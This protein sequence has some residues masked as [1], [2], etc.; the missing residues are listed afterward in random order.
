ML[1]VACEIWVLI[2]LYVELADH[3]IP[4]V[5]CGQ[6]AVRDAR[7]WSPMRRSCAWA[8]RRSFTPTMVPGDGS[9]DQLTREAA[10]AAPGR[11]AC[12]CEK[13]AQGAAAPKAWT[14]GSAAVVEGHLIAVGVGERDRP[15]GAGAT[16]RRQAYVFAAFTWLPVGLRSR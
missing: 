10:S 12:R 8:W 2:A 5:T 3:I 11:L 1:A 7:R 16:G 15:G 6:V 4:A 14:P 9:R 13:P